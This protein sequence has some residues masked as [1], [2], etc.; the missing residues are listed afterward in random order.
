MGKKKE[1]FKERLAMG[2]S[3][4]TE[5][6]AFQSETKPKLKPACGYEYGGLI[7]KTKADAEK[8]YRSGLLSEFCFKA[9]K[10]SYHPLYFRETILAYWDEVKAIMES[11]LE[12][13]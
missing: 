3:G 12:V 9:Q 2:T 6:V 10:G 4:P 11:T 13:E 8:A 1:D 7:Y 5:K